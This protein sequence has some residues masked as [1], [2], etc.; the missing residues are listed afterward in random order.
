M[1]TRAPGFDARR[2]RL[3]PVG[4]ETRDG[5]LQR[6]GERQLGGR[7]VLVARIVR[8]VALDRRASSGGGAIA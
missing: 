1:M 4:Q 6:F 5:V 8:R 7:Q 2:D 3:V